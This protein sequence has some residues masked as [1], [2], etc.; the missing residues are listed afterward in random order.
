MRTLQCD[1]TTTLQTVQSSATTLSQKSID[2]DVA[3]KDIAAGANNVSTA[4][5]NIT[6]GAEQQTAHIT[7]IT[8]HMEQFSHTVATTAEES[9]TLQQL[10][11][12]S[13]SMSEQG[14]QFMSEAQQKMQHVEQLMHRSVDD[15]HAL[16]E[17]S[18]HISSFVAIIENV[19]NETNLLALNASIEAARAGEHG[20]GFAVVA[21]EVRHLAEQTAKSVHEITTL[22]QTIQQR[23]STLQ[24]S[25]QNGAAETVT[26]AQALDVTAQ[27]FTHLTSS[28]QE[29]AQFVNHLHAQFTTITHESTSIYGALQQMTSV[30]EE[31]TASIEETTAT[32]QETTST[33]MQISVASEQLAALS[34]QLEEIVQQYALR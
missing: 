12:H 26:T 24:Q 28:I 8:D 22:V 31:T 19:A 21:E 1:L 25:L 13:L 4:M 29:V 2:L 20:K 15:L 14:A 34:K 11:T 32:M 33:M 9:N 5:D 6:D 23:T 16:E 27:S 7:L 18:S 30:T 3:T 17:Q 10:T